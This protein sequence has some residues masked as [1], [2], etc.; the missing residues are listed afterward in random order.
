MEKR[1]TIPDNVQVTVKGRKFT[2]KGSKGELT[3]DFSDPRFDK[4]ISI[5]KTGNEIV[6]LGPDRR[7]MKSMIGTIISHTNNMIL[8]VTKGHRYKMKIV[9]THFPITVEVKE[10]KV[11]VRNFLGEKGARVAKVRGNVDI[12]VQKDDITITSSDKEAAGQTAANIEKICKVSKRDRRIFS[13]G[14]F[15]VGHEI[16]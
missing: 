11:L 9:F 14:I 1:L 8:G 3:R 12:K 16:E 6:V 15:I 10:G 7:K 5:E 13:D 4:Q 2:F